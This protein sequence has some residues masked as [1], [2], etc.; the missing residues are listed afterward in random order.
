MLIPT[1][2]G[3]AAEY[4]LVFSAQVPNVPNLANV[5]D[6]PEQH[7]RPRPLLIRQLGGCEKSSCSIEE[8]SENDSFEGDYDSDSGL[9]ASPRFRSHRTKDTG[10]GGASRE[11]TKRI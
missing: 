6:V 10:F 5:S 4:R 9:P 2:A 8:E 7:K 11:P 1:V 3:S